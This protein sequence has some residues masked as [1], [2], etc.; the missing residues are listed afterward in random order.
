M[1][2]AEQDETRRNDGDAIAE[3]AKPR[4]TFG[5]MGLAPSLVRALGS[6][7]IT[8][9]TP[10]Q[11]DS[12]PLILQGNDLIGGSPTGSGKTL[13]FALPIL[14]TLMKD[15]V[16]GFAVVLTPTREL[17]MQLYEQF[18]A[19]GEGARMGLRVALIVGG[20]DIVRQSSELSKS[21]PHIIVATPGRLRDI[22]ESGGSQ[23]WSLDRCKFVVLD[24]ADRLLTPTFGPELGFLFENLPPARSRQ[25]LLFT[26]TLTDE[27]EALSQREPE[28]GARKPI[29]CKIQQSTS[30]PP[31]LKQQYLFVPSHMREPYL[32]HLLL[33]API[34]SDDAFGQEDEDGD[35]EEDGPKVPFSIIFVSRSQ[36]AALLSHM[37]Q[38][39]GIPNVALHSTLSQPQRL[40]AL[41]TFRSRSVPILVTT[42]LGSRGLDVPDVELV[43]NWDLPRDWRD[44]VHRVGRTARNGKEGVA[45]NFVGERDV[46]IFKAIEDT[47]GVNMTEVAN[48]REDDVLQQLNPVMTAKRMASMHL[49]DSHFGAQKE[50]NQAKAAMRMRDVQRTGRDSKK[51]KKRST[52]N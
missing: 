34:E 10:I 45:V 21:R 15:M 1:D 26:A 24:E 43:V 13:S 50:R 33:H 46:E 19:V 36:T 18:L 4:K 3:S 40:E 9:P 52:K 2:G 27:I 6:L 51:H 30:T 16:G 42:D 44:Y 29:L 32:Y 41:R 47:I 38:Q 7:R 14:Q 23:E 11:R 25:T 37:L 39:L 31:T 12:I 49:H 35:E 28:Q 8:H 17:A 5:S 48:M 22:I 20:L